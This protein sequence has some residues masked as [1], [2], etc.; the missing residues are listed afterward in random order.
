MQHSSAKCSLRQQQNSYSLQQADLQHSWSRGVRC[1]TNTLRRRT[2][3]QHIRFSLEEI[4]EPDQTQALLS[5]ATLCST[6]LYKSAVGVFRA[7]LAL[8]RQQRLYT[9]PISSAAVESVRLRAKC[10]TQLFHVTRSLLTSRARHYNTWKRHFL[11]G[12]SPS[13]RNAERMSAMDSLGLLRSGGR[14]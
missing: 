2:E 8:H 13:E 4:K 9:Q 6:D 5:N 1:R 12:T 14:R 3:R 11:S 7:H 10:N